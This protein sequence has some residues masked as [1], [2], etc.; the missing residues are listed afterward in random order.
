[1]KKAY[2][3]AVLYAFLIGFSFMA[4]KITVSTT[5][6]ETVL[7]HR[8]LLGALF[9]VVY[10]LVTRTK[11]T[12]TKKDL[13]VLL[14][15]SISYPILYFLVQALALSKIGSGEVGIVFAGSPAIALFIAS[16]FLKEKS[17]M[18]QKL[19][20]TLSIGGVI[21]I[22]IMQGID[23]SGDVMGYIY[24]VLAALVFAIYNTHARFVVKNYSFFDVTELLLYVGAIFYNVIAI[25][26]GINYYVEPFA[27]INYIIAVLYIGTFASVLASLCATYSLQTISASQL[28]IFSNLATLISILAGVLILGEQIYWYHIVSTVLI[29][30]GVLLA[31]KVIKKAQ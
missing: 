19:G 5:T 23:L 21:L 9:F 28:T 22:F 24:A 2:I 27:Q 17:T 31:N 1:M 29:I 4:T 14:P 13:K 10:R 12:I 25:T 20:I 18:L 26:K 7:A 8:F 15:L 16:V 11:S 30:S 6:T 3:S